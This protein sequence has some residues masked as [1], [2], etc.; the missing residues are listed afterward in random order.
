VSGGRNG[1]AL[2]HLD[3]VFGKQITIV[4]VIVYNFLLEVRQVFFYSIF[5]HVV[6]TICSVCGVCYVLCVLVL[7]LLVVMC[8]VCYR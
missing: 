2:H 8:D 1:A 6:V 3:R 5:F 4:L 7:R